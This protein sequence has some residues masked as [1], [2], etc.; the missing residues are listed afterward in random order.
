[1]PPHKGPNII[2]YCVITSTLSLGVVVLAQIPQFKVHK[3]KLLCAEYISQKDSME[4]LNK[5]AKIYKKFIGN[6]SANVINYC[7]SL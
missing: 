4:G 6:Q 1:M 7:N 2:R 5:R 3:A